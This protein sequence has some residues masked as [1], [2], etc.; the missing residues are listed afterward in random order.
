MFLYQSQQ[1]IKLNLKEK[2]QKASLQRWVNNI[3]DILKRNNIVF[4]INLTSIDI[5]H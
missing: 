5:N 2:E 1:N 4:L 3:P